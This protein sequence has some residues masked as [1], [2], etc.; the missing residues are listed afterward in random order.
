MLNRDVRACKPS[1]NV[2]SI[3]SGTIMSYV[4][5]YSKQDIPVLIVELETWDVPCEL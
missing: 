5:I 4:V 3:V 2:L 1:A